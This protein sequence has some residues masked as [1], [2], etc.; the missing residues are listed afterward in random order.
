MEKLRAAMVPY[1]AQARS[2]YSDAKARYLK[3]LPSGQHFFV[4]TTLQ[5]GS[6]REEQVFVAV[7]SIENGF[8]QGTIFSQIQLVSG[9]R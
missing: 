2:S 1:I 7:N 6:G 5:D 9:F 3:G 4:T 8:I